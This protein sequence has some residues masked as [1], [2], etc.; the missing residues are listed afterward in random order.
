MNKENLVIWACDFTDGFNYDE[1]N[2]CVIMPP[3][4][5]ALEM[6]QFIADKVMYTFLL[7]SAVLDYSGIEVTSNCERL[8]VQ[9]SG[10][11]ESKTVEYGENVV[12]AY[13]EVLQYIQD[14][15]HF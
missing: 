15:E 9:I 12:E 6:E 10:M 2:N 3:N 5:T 14:L 13:E 1:E 7:Q 8:T 11:E 4:G